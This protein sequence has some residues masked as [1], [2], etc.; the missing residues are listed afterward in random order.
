MN[1]ATPLMRAVESSKP[2][3]VQYLI[4]KGAKVQVENKKGNWIHVLFLYYKAI[5]KELFLY[6][7]KMLTRCILD[8]LFTEMFFQDPP[9]AYYFY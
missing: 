6:L 2:E 9:I 7:F 4:E 3:L 1:G 5:E 8:E